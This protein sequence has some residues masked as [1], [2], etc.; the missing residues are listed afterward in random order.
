[1]REPSHVNLLKGFKTSTT[2]NLCFIF[3]GIIFHYVGG[4]DFCLHTTAK[5]KEHKLGPRAQG[6]QSVLFLPIQHLPPH[7]ASLSSIQPSRPER[8]FSTELG[9][10]LKARQFCKRQHEATV[11][12]NHFRTTALKTYCAVSVDTPQK[13]KVLPFI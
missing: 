2:E 13:H 3:L 4:C 8:T 7:S 11:C 6:S 12:R 5:C 9:E 10:Q 1:M